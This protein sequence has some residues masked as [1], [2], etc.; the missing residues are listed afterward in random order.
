MHQLTLATLA[1]VEAALPEET[2]TVA[3]ITGATSLSPQTF[4]HTNS[5]TCQFFNHIMWLT[6]KPNT[7]RVNSWG[8][9][10]KLN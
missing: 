3:H 5:L 8:T 6:K 1:P 7:S 9:I 4:R 10:K 2:A